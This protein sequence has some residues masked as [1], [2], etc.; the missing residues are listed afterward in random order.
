MCII[1]DV[2]VIYTISYAYTC[3]HMR[4]RI[5]LFQCLSNSTL[6]SL[7]NESN[8][9]VDNHLVVRPCMTGKSSRELALPG[10][11]RTSLASL[12]GE[13]RTSRVLG[14]CLLATLNLKP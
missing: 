14:F 9:D 8:I 2:H 5:Q 1:I 3:N 11:S 7:S 13:H 4:T 6:T 12:S 10:P